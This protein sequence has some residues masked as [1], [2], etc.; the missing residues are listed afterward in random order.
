MVEW[1]SLCFEPPTNALFVP[2]AMA[3]RNDWYWLIWNRDRVPPLE[4]FALANYSDP[5]E[6]TPQFRSW[7]TSRLDDG[8][9]SI[10][11]DTSSFLCTSRQVFEDRRWLVWT[12]IK[13]F[14]WW[15]CSDRILWNKQRQRTRSRS[16]RTNYH[17][18]YQG[19]W[20]L[21]LVSTDLEKSVIFLE[22]TLTDPSEWFD[23]L[24]L[25]PR[26]GLC[27]QPQ[28]SSLQR[29]NGWQSYPTNEIVPRSLK[30]NVIRP[31]PSREKRKFTS[32]VTVE[33]GC[34]HWRLILHLMMICSVMVV[35]A[36]SVRT[37]DSVRNDWPIAAVRQLSLWVV[38]G[39][40]SNKPGLLKV[41]TIRRANASGRCDE[42]YCICSRSRATHWKDNNNR[43]NHQ[44]CIS[45]SS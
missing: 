29:V 7:T 33:N 28:D 17:I 26:P 34:W 3:R 21:F 32:C 10:S 36:F 15:A 31:W 25:A 20:L 42:R 4:G 41:T 18:W 39:R 2:I 37:R 1:L 38:K 35:M 11:G 14:P 9:I 22:L 13:R 5:C 16:R 30:S 8:V 44:L 27:L 6:L 43:L 12:V 40:V 19:A 24:R 45:V 23:V